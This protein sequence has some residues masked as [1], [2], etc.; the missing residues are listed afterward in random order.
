MEDLADMMVKESH[1]S[2]YGEQMRMESDRRIECLTQGLSMGRRSQ[3]WGEW[4]VAT[5]REARRMLWRGQLPNQ[6][7]LDEARHIVAPSY[8]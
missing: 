5:I 2:R 6:E 7:E 4:G 3:K 8:A 1:P